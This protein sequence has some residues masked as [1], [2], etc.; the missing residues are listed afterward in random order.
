LLSSATET[1]IS[2]VPNKMATIIFF[3]IRYS[4]QK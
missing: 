1:C 2:A 4:D 3:I